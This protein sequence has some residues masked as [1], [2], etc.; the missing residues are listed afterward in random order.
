MGWVQAC[1]AR[2][3]CYSRSGPPF[4]LFDT[5]YKWLHRTGLISVRVGGGDCSGQRFGVVA[6]WEKGGFEGADR[7]DFSPTNPG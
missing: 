4:H 5:F 3:Q 2:R 6:H 7:L 1:H